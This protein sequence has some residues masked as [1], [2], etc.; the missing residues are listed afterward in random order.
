MPEPQ[1]TG[2]TL[3][4]AADRT[5][6]FE[7]RFEAEEVPVWDDFV[8]R[9]RFRSARLV[10]VDGGSE[11]TDGVQDYLLQIVAADAGAHSEHDR[12]PRFSAFLDW[13]R[14]LQPKPPLVWFGRTVFEREM[15]PG[16]GAG[17]AR[18]RR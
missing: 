16:Q 3:R 4:I 18:P 13:A 2:L 6:E 12:D 9:G 8:A 15:G 14:T 1:I 17:E 10:R 7:A 5:P 11:V